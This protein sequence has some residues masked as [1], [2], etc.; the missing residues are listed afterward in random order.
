MTMLLLLLLLMMMMMIFLLLPFV[1]L[2]CVRPVS[3]LP[4][5]STPP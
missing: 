4:L 1:K 5:P 3:L 2:A